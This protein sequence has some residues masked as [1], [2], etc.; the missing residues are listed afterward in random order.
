MELAR[1]KSPLTAKSILGYAECGM[2]V[3]DNLT[4]IREDIVEYLDQHGPP[5]P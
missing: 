1:F 4:Q 3:E 5:P 2:D